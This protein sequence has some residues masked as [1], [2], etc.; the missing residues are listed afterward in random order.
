MA[1]IEVETLTVVVQEP[2]QLNAAELVIGAYTTTDAE[3]I[4]SVT[5]SLRG[6][7][8]KSGAA[9]EGI[10]LSDFI[11]Y[12]LAKAHQEHDAFGGVMEG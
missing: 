4:Q 1:R 8:E 6:Y 11:L 5:D 9:G 2:G 10:S 3:L 7:I 12:L